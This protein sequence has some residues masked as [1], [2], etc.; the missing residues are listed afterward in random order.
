MFCSVIGNSS[1]PLYDLYD[2]YIPGTVSNNRKSG[3]WVC[4][5]RSIRPL[6]VAPLFWRKI[7]RGTLQSV[8]WFGNFMV[9]YTSLF[10]TIYKWCWSGNL[11][12]RDC[13]RH[14]SWCQCRTFCFYGYL[15]WANGLSSYMSWS[16]SAH[17]RRSQVRSEHWDVLFASRGEHCKSTAVPIARPPSWQCWAM[18]PFGLQ[19]DSANLGMGKWQPLF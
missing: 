12:S 4:R 9:Y 11:N 10:L 6:F 2:T 13:S 8:D 5:S 17:E 19:S 16:V 14:S 3:N 7:K 18:L 15:L 1:L